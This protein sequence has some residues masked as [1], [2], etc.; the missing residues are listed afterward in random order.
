[1][2]DGSV[3]STES[4][5]ALWEPD[6]SSAEVLPS[7]NEVAGGLP[8]AISSRARLLRKTSSMLASTRATAAIPPATPP[9]RCHLEC[10]TLACLTERMTE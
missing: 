10:Y 5:R 1:M 6:G 9:A 2:G 8:L 3:K 4:G 7:V